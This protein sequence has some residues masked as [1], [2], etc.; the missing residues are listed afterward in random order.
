MPLPLPHG[1]SARQGEHAHP[2]RRPAL[3]RRGLPCVREATG[4][5]RDERTL[6]SP[7]DAHAWCGGRA[8][9]TRP[10][11]WQAKTKRE[12]TDDDHPRLRDG[13]RATAPPVSI[14]NMPPH[15]DWTIHVA[16][17]CAGP[18][19]QKRRSTR[20]P[21]HTM[22]ACRLPPALL[23]SDPMPGAPAACIICVSIFHF[24]SSACISD[25]RTMQGMPVISVV[26]ASS[27]RPAATSISPSSRDGRTHARQSSVLCFCAC[28]GVTCS[29]DVWGSRPDDAGSD[30]ITSLDEPMK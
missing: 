29:S 28:G 2:S 6:S 5:D 20:A 15:P 9:T 3:L 16:S 1:A 22:P 24:D 17:L 27:H 8:P 23:S 30:Q 21:L 13:C 7:C 26:S 11:R 4:D 10:T 12:L 19:R 18:H 14:Q 25:S